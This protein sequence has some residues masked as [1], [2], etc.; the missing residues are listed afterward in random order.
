M[1]HDQAQLLRQ[2]VNGKLEEK[3]IKHQKE[4]YIITVASGKGGVGKSNFSVN[5]ALALKGLGKNPII[6]DAD[7]GLANVEVILGEHPKYNMSHLI[8]G[9]CQMKDLISESKYGVSFISGGSGIKD[10][11]FLPSYRIADISRKL[12]QLSEVTDILIIDTGAGINDIVVKFCNLAEQ[13]FIIVTPEP[14]SIT[15][16][17]ALLKT[18]VSNFGLESR[19]K[20]I[21][22]KAD[23]QKEAHEVYR[24]LRHV[25]Q[26]FLQFPVDYAGF[27]PYDEQ[28]FRAVKEQV[29]IFKYNLHAKSSRAYYQIA[30]AYLMELGEQVE[31]NANMGNEKENWLSKFKRLFEQ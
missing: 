6:L 12:G 1:S 7:F 23:S 15:D 29:P 27:V 30:K 2:M 21:I 20:L 4:M 10:M 17:Y 5:L 9:E 8:N 11:S 22:N 3:P 26:Q 25:C 18:L 31:Q 24:K 19:V 28:V 13:V 16:S 14:T